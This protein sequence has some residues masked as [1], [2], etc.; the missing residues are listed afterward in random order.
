MK[1]C[2]CNGALDES[3]VMMDRGDG[4]GASVTDELEL[5]VAC[6]RWKR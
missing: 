5:G 2:L 4:Y 3:R 6:Q 1:E